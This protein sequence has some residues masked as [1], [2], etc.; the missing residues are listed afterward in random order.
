MG[1]SEHEAAVWG[2]TPEKSLFTAHLI[3]AGH[4]FT[5]N[6]GVYHLSTN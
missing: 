5:R 3:N 4:S 1:V 2:Y 6:D